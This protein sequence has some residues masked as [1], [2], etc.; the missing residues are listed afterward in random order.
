MSDLFSSLTMASRALDAQR[1]GLDVVGQNIANINTPGYARRQLDLASVPPTDRLSAGGGVDVVGIRSTRDAL[2]ERRVRLER[3]AEGRESAL[4]DALSVV[5]AALGAPGESIDG[6]FTAFVNSWASLSEDPT[7]S[8]MRQGVILQ[9]QS[10]ASAFN[11]MSERFTA[12]RLDAD[13]RVKGI[14]DTVNGLV[15]RI[16]ALNDSI[17][18]GGGSSSMTLSLSDDLSEN[19]KQLSQ[20]VDV[21]VLDNKSGGVDVSFANGRAL[22]IGT[23]AYKLDVVTNSDGF[24]DLQTGGVS[25]TGEITGGQLGG[26]LHARDVVIPGYIDSLDS[27]AYTLV[28]EVNT[29]HTAGRDLNG[30]PA[31]NFFTP[32]AAQTGAAAAITVN[33]AL[34]ADPRL[35]AAAATAAVGDNGNARIL[36]ALGDKKVLNGGAGTFNDGWAELTYRIGQ[37]T[38]TARAEQKNRAEIVTQIDALRGAVSGVSLDQEAMTMLKFQRAYEANAKFFTTINQALDTLMAM[39]GH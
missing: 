21:N 26:M 28:R 22:V 6:K 11:G 13:N 24:A 33:P 38:A 18:R 17:G 35:V 10:L 8:T 23:N 37:D 36:A 27:M 2:L 29:Q 19:I 16:A 39:V 15:Q 14:A 4:A 34:A 3:P 7:S 9:G 20:L 30:N 1:L 12:A 25:V 31:A 5:E 32:L